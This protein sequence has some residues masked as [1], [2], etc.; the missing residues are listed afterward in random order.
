[1]PEGTRGTA[2]PWASAVEVRGRS[3]SPVRGATCRTRGSATST[4]RAHHR[5]PNGALEATSTTTASRTPRRGG[6]HRTTTVR[7]PRWRP[8]ACCSGPT[9]YRGRSRTGRSTSQ[10]SSST[11][12]ARPSA[13]QAVHTIPTRRAGTTGATRPTSR[14]APS[15]APT[16]WTQPEPLEWATPD[17][18]SMV[19]MLPATGPIQ[20][21]GWA[22]RRRRTPRGMAGE[23]AGRCWRWSR[24]EASVPTIRAAPP[25]T[26]PTGAASGPNSARETATPI[27][28][29]AMPTRAACTARHRPCRG[30]GAAVRLTWWGRG[31]RR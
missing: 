30:R 11:C 20:A 3:C 7:G 14:K 19:M 13:G 17:Q 12:P 29:A 2:S 5:R 1:M 9:G 6:V 4:S 21:T 24:H 18:A 8:P 16:A 26:I 10:V 25:M 27:M 28:P 23:T 31:C 15:S 22:R